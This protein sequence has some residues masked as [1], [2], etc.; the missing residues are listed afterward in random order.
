MCL[1]SV[2]LLGTMVSVIRLVPHTDLDNFRHYRTAIAYAWR[3][4]FWPLYLAV[5]WAMTCV[6][7]LQPALGVASCSHASH[8]QSRE[9][10]GF[11]LSGR[12][13]P[14]CR[15]SQSGQRHV[16]QRSSDRCIN[17]G[18][19]SLPVP[20]W[21]ESSLMSKVSQSLA[22]VGSRN[23]RGRVTSYIALDAF[24]TE[25][26]PLWNGTLSSDAIAEFSRLADSLIVATRRYE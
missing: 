18:R 23:A 5:I 16:H 22:G 12:Y 26:A 3:T 14:S 24:L 7:L 11:L 17:P 25:Q 1:L 15:V 8:L 6:Y 20:R 21:P 9:P 13:Q 19:R 10:S 4:S 2:P